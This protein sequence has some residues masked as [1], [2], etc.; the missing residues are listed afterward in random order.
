MITLT[1][2]TLSDAYCSTDN[3]IIV[4]IVP[5]KCRSEDKQGVL[6]EVA[7]LICHNSRNSFKG[8]MLSLQ[9][10]F[11]RQKGFEDLVNLSLYL[12]NGAKIKN[13]GSQNNMFGSV[14]PLRAK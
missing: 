1:V 4:I 5:I 8:V 14:I 2:I 12:I 3:C 10:F 9:A 11:N 13:R 7:Y 6:L